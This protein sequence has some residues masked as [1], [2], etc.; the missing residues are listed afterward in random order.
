MGT[1]TYND[2]TLVSQISQKFDQDDQIKYCLR[3]SSKD[4]AAQTIKCY[5]C[6]P[7]YNT[8]AQIIHHI[9]QRRFRCP[10]FIIAKR[11]Q[12]GIGFVGWT[13]Q[14]NLLA[15]SW[16]VKESAQYCSLEVYMRIV[17]TDDCNSTS[18]PR[19]ILTLDQ[20]SGYNNFVKGRTL[21]SLMWKG[22]RLIPGTSTLVMYGLAVD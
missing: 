3:L 21:T 10:N 12:E 19:L 9:M 6:C 5:F 2:F 7:K 11:P 15:L 17:K 4:N 1:T 13:K 22:R 14:T 8:A 20:R 16:R 18:E